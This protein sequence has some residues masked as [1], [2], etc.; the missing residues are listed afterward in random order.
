MSRRNYWSRN[1]IS[2]FI[3]Y[4]LF[5]LNFLFWVG[6]VLFVALS[7]WL[8]IDKNKLVRNW[9]EFFLDPVSLICLSGGIVVFVAFFGCMGSLREKTCFLHVYEISM[10]V[11]L[12]CEIV[13]SLFFFV[14]YSKPGLMTEINMEKFFKGVVKS[15][16]EDL[17][18][19]NFIDN[20]QQKL[21]CCGMNDDPNTGYKDWNSNMYFT[22]SAN[23]TSPEKCSVPFSCCKKKE[24]GLINLKCGNKMLDDNMFSKFGS[25]I[26]TRGCQYAIRMWI[27][28]NML[29]LGGIILGILIPQFFLIHLVR[30]FKSQIAH[31]RAKL[32]RSEMLLLQ[33]E[34]HGD[35]SHI[36]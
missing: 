17:D 25:A 30:A 34:G 36:S 33:V 15:Y 12:I 3:K 2:M 26:N 14:I 7:T 20:F 31:Q 28:N 13:L 4:T 19:Q 27:T 10:V 35:I 29:K 11:V 1:E 8:L 32:K 9:M 16:R 22:C 23:N 24:N 21:E 6:G 5:S 18:Q